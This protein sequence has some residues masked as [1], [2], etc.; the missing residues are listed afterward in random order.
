MVISFCQNWNTLS[1]HSVLNS[2]W[3]KGF[4]NGTRGCGRLYWP[5]NSLT[6]SNHELF[7]ARFPIKELHATWWRIFPLRWQIIEKRVKMSLKWKGSSKKINCTIWSAIRKLHQSGK[8]YFVIMTNLL[9]LCFGQ[10]KRCK[11]RES[12][13]KRIIIVRKINFVRIINL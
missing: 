9:Y 7:F 5:H 11:P 6:W 10:E 2:F 13:R 12:S 3:G 4:S 1:L 8:I